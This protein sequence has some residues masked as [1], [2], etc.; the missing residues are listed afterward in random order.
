MAC[1]V[2]LHQDKITNVPPPLRPPGSGSL[3]HAMPAFLLLQHLLCAHSS[4]AHTPRHLAE[5]PFTSIRTG[6]WPSPQQRPSS[7]DIHDIDTGPF[8]TTVTGCRLTSHG[9]CMRRTYKH[10][11]A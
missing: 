9:V 2:E 7:L 5:Y 11:P 4:A 10:R 8:T 6:I 1:R 3:L